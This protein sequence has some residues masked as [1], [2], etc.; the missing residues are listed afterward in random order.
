M[1]SRK[2]FYVRKGGPKKDVTNARVESLNG[3]LL[4][5]I[6]EV[7]FQCDQK[8]EYIGHVLSNRTFCKF[9]DFKYSKKEKNTWV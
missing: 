1:R 2:K 3:S 8:N 6:H 9:N 7:E 4:K 5:T